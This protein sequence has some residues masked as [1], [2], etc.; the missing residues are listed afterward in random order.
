[1]KYVAVFCS[2]QDVE[3][4]YLE[5]AR[6]FGK[7]LNKYDYHLVWGGSDRGI[8]KV[9][10]DVVQEGGGKLYGVS[11]DLFHHFSRK[12]ADEMIIAKTLGERKGAMLEKADAV[13]ALVGGIG[14]LDEITEIIELKKTHHHDKP[15]VILN[16]DH[17]YDGL[18]ALIQKMEDEGFLKSNLNKEKN[19]IVYFAETPEKAIEYINKK[20]K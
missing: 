2:S 10:A 14:T 7:L 13:V 3:E 6:E 20:F 9:I 5:S 15:I 18:K 8:M 16:T 17:F 11:Y 12:N 1:M 4:K 19:E